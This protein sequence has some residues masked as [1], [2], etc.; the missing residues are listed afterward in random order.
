L[1]RR[2]FVL[3]LEFLWVVLKLQVQLRRF[4]NLSPLAEKSRHEF[5]I[6][7]FKPIGLK[8]GWLLYDILPDPASDKYIRRRSTEALIILR[9]K[10][11][12]HDRL[13]NKRDRPFKGLFNFVILIQEYNSCYAQRLSWLRKEWGEMDWQCEMPQRN[14]V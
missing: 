8:V 6:D 7:Q 1:K 2:I 11:F 14:W 5:I 4:R 10:F 3:F 12:E 13:E 9:D